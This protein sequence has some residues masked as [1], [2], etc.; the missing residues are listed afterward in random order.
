MLTICMVGKEGIDIGLQA[1]IE[2]CL[3]YLLTEL[4]QKI[5]S[6]LQI[7]NKQLNL[8]ILA[9]KNER[10]RIQA[11]YEVDMEKNTDHTRTSRQN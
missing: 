7:E 3:T 4:K 1:T 5:I 2:E 11:H 10:N 9:I 8:Q 6:K